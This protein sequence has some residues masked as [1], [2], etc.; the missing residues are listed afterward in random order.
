MPYDRP[1]RD[2]GPIRLSG[3]ERPRPAPAR[4]DTSPVVPA[5]APARPPVHAPVHARQQP[6]APAAAPAAP[7]SPG[8]TAAARMRRSIERARSRQ[9]CEWFEL[10]RLCAR[11]RCRRAGGC[12]GEPSACLRTGLAQAPAAVAELARRIQEAQQQGLDME[13]AFEEL[14]DCHDVFFA[15]TAGLAAAASRSAGAHRRTRQPAPRPPR[16]RRKSGAV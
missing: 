8:E 9:L 3:R 2:P 11:P 15:W 7:P 4:H 10:D 16:A 12:R 13:A 5:Q 6:T 1:L 14:A